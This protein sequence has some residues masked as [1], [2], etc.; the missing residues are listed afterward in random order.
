MK[1]FCFRMHDEMVIENNGF[2]TIPIKKKASKIIILNENCY[3]I[4]I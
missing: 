2:I 4:I 3:C 1:Y